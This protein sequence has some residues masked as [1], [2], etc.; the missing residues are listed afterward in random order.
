GRV[1]DALDKIDPG[2]G[3]PVVG[4]EPPEIYCLKHDYLD[5]LPER[6]AEIRQRIPGVWLMDE[7]LVRSP[8]FQNLRIGSKG[9]VFEMDSRNKLWFHPHCHQRAE[10][11]SEDGLPT[12]TNA[13]LELLRLCG[14]DV[15]LIDSG[16]CGMAGTFGYEAEH[17]DLSMK[18]GE[19]RLFPLLKT[20]S[21]LGTSPKS[22]IERLDVNSTSTIEFGGGWEGVLSSGAACRLQIS[23]GTG[24]EAVHPILAVASRL[25]EL[26]HAKE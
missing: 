18:V 24:V 9:P 4:I 15:E 19:L 1:L 23:Q 2:R 6:E 12:G 17:Y 14:F 16:C 20:R 5:L 25:K 11:L 8:E 7:F 26:S 21:A 13:T 3:A 10:G 22:D